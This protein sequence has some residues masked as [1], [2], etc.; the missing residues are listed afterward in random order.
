M[1]PLTMIH[2]H[3]KNKLSSSDLVYANTRQVAERAD[4]RRHLNYKMKSRDSMS[5]CIHEFINIRLSG[6]VGQQQVWG[7]SVLEA[8]SAQST[9]RRSRPCSMK[10]RQRERALAGSTRRTLPEQIHRGTT[11][12]RASR[13]SAAQPREDKPRGTP[14]LSTSLLLYR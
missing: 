5:G 10:A 12:S 1:L 4:E 3:P 9:C 14:P 11:A 13:R 6:N 7:E 8:T 2:A